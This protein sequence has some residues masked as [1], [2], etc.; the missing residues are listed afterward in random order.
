[1][2]LDLLY[3]IDAPKPWGKPHPYGQREAEQR[4]YREA[5]EQIK[6]ADSVGFNTIWAVE[7]HFREG[8]S[9]MPAPE[10]VLGALSQV[11][12]QIRLGFGVTLTRSAL[13]RPSGSPRRWPR[14][15][16][17]RAAGWSGVPGVRPRWSRRVPCRSRAVP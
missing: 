8:R 7:H 9:H 14:S 6:L 12:E 4:S 1:M 10:T 3:E 11:T 15:T 13:P 16:S 5:I 17:C 2:K